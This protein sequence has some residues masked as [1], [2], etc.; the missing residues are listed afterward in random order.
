MDGKPYSISSMRR[1]FRQY[2][3]PTREELNELWQ[4]GLFSFD[5]SVLLN[6]YGYSK[7][8]REEVVEFVETNAARVRLPYQFGLEYARNRTK[9][10]VKQV[11]NYLRVE[12]ALRKI[13]DVDIAPKF[14]HPYLSKKSARAYQAIL[15]ELEESRKA[16]EKLIGSDPYAEKLFEV[17]EGKVGKC[18]APEQLSAL[19]EEVQRRYDKRTPPGFADLKQKAPPDAYGD[20]IAWLQL[21]DIAKAEQK[22]VILV[23]DDGKD[24]WWLFERGRNAGP[25]PE[26]LA[27]FFGVTQQ[28]FYMYNSETFLR[29]VKEFTLA[30]IRDDVIEEVSQ[31]LASQRETERAVDLKSIPSESALDS[32]KGSNPS[33]DKIGD[34]KQALIVDSDP[35]KDKLG[36][37]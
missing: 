35:G 16:M 29:S 28:Q 17:F 24:D 33:Q 14:D 9:V 37:N 5:A 8:T 19:H 32:E 12:D 27:E 1:T 3:R 21:M 34:L 15:N 36:Q 23:I 26:L 7:K 13:K 11:S 30:E 6:L 10:I 4:H 25:L 20:C 22:G 18:P 31:R 2:F